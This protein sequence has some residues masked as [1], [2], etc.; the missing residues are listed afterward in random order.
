MPDLLVD[1]M[2][3][4]M[5]RFRLGK[6]H[7]LDSGGED[8]L[9]A[10]AVAWSCVAA[11]EE[12]RVERNFLVLLSVRAAQSVAVCKTV[13]PDDPEVACLTLGVAAVIQHIG[14]CTSW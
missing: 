3:L 14:D 12:S 7:Y 6:L 8:F 2:K 13:S 9:L 4:V 5:R 10:D 1:L 11:D